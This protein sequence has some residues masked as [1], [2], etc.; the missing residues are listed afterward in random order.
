MRLVDVWA[1]HYTQVMYEF[2]DQ[3][4][5]LVAA[6]SFFDLLMVKPGYEIGT[7]YEELRGDSCG[8]AFCR[9]V[10]NLGACINMLVTMGEIQ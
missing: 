4:H 5:A 10:I 9:Y 8:V 1:I 3:N 7:V 6:K 2:D